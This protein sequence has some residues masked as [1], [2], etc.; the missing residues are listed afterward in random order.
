MFKSVLILIL[1]GFVAFSAEKLTE[2]ARV[3]RPTDNW[4]VGELVIDLKAGTQATITLT[5]CPLG[6]DASGNPSLGGPKGGYPI[7]ISDRSNPA[8]SESVYVTGGTCKSEAATG[9][10]VVTPY[11][12]HQ[13]KTYSIGSASS[14]IQEAINDACGTAAEPYKNG[15]CHVIVPP[16][17]PQIVDNVGYDTFD[18]I[19]FHANGSALSGYGAILN[20]HG[21]GP[22]LQVGDL[23]N[24]NHYTGDTV[25]GISFRRT[26][27]RKADPAFSGSRIRS[28]LRKDGLVTV[29]T[30]NPHNLRS[31][32]MVS[33]MLTDSV[34]YWGDVPSIT[35][36]DSTH[37]TYTRASTPDIPQQTTPGVVALATVAILDNSLST[38]LVDIQLEKSGEYG[39]FN[40]FFD[41]WDDEN[42]VVEKFTNN[43]I[44]LNQN[45][46]W[47]GSFV[48][49]GG[50]LS[51]PDKRHQLAPVITL[52]DSS[53]TANGSN[54]ATVYN[55]NGFYVENT[56]CEA[57][58]P[59]QFLVSNT[60]GNYQGAEFRDVYSESALTLNPAR[61]AAS[62]WYGLG[63]GGF[64]GGRTSGGYTL[65]GQGWFSGVLPTTGKGLDTYVY[66]IVA[67]DLTTGAQT[68]PLPFLYAKQDA[69][70]EIVTR[71]P[72]IA[73]GTDKIVY[74]LIRNY[75]PA[76]T[77]D[78][79]AGGYVGPHD[80]NCGGGQP[81]R[82]GAVGVD[83]GQCDGF[84]CQFTDRTA[85]ATQAYKVRNGNFSPNPTFWPGSVVLT[86]T[87][88]ITD[89]EIPAT[90]MAFLGMPS[91]YALYCNAY[92]GNVSG[93]YTVCTGS[94]LATN[95]AVPNQTALILTDG[96]NTGGGG[97]IGAKGR[98][99]FE[100]NGSGSLNPHQIIT[101]FNFDPTKTVATTGYRPSGD[102]QDMYLGTN[103][104]GELTVGGG[105][106]GIA[107]YIDN[108]GVDNNWL[109]HLT[110]S[111]KS[112][113]V[114][115]E[116]PT[117]NS[118]NGFQIN[119]SYGLAGQC[120]VSTGTASS[121]ASCSGL[122]RSKGGDNE[123]SQTP[124]GKLAGSSD[125]SGPIPNGKC[126]DAD[127][128]T[129]ANPSDFLIPAWPADLNPG[130]LGSMFI[131]AE[132][133]VSVR[134]CNFSGAPAAPGVLHF[135]ARVSH[136]DLYKSAS[137]G[138]SQIPNERCENQLL[139]LDGVLAGDA[140]IP[141][142]PPTLGQGLIGSMRASADNVVEVRLCN[143]SGK[144]ITVPPQVFGVSIAK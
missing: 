94:M 11:F 1:S 58:G 77:I 17:G 139:T 31:G 8:N 126:A 14:G 30:A 78:V 103:A 29:E 80:A 143:F 124:V 131:S 69:P 113:R 101:L 56:V 65:R 15:G 13:A 142:W 129:D 10:I 49:S 47:T 53:M 116:A 96:T 107:I 26:D 81:K 40:H 23:L 2:K 87:P 42:A 117:V 92:G 68:S 38:R 63:I 135:S 130:L 21:R 12:S 60:N 95:N 118:V 90:G 19:Y 82:C 75:A 88:L 64:I 39:R 132:G 110:A 55:S 70:G 25:E 133:R 141:K 100:T 45:E 114:P 102:P 73:S 108:T 104:A 27:D 52:K 72:R 33:Q 120:L 128:G 32:D 57:Q 36:A 127:F 71:W 7:R 99:I 97:V 4:S 86:S 144:A 24:S 89:R 16:V 6:V 5:P 67:R 83:L 105:Q 61:P 34:N 28:T 50:A 9:T 115:I 66:Y 62:P 123:L 46:N 112:F 91:E 106:K 137:L 54:C 22:C 18:V 37:Y 59:W 76:G 79:A 74:D 93:G 98:L 35:V 140:V 43:A 3:V 109:E 85:N 84:I 119:G 48:W 122:S 20:C 111:R 134:L 44:P 41:F 125:F 136:L 51:L 121:W 138:F